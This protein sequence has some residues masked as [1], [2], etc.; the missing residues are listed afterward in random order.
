M[1]GDIL[2]AVRASSQ[3]LKNAIIRSVTLEQATRTVTIEIV[4]D[5]TFTE[6]DKNA[7]T[8]A[9]LPAVPKYFKCNVS[10]IKL[11]PD[12]KM[13]EKKI[14][15][16]ISLNFKAIYVTLKEGD[17]RV[18]KTDYGF[19]YTVAVMRFLQIGQDFCDKINAFLKSNFCG[20]FRGACVPSERGISDISVE[21]KQDEIEFQIPVRTFAI[22]DFGYLEGTKKLTTAVYLA[23]LNFAAEEVVVCGVIE[24]ITER[25]YTNKKGIQKSFLS[26]IISDTT[27]SVHI[28]YFI[29][30]KSYEKIKALKVGDSIVCTGSNE[31]YNGC[32][33]YT[34][35]TIDYGKYPK[36]FVPEKRES[37]PVPKYYHCVEPQPFSDCEQTDLFTKSV[38]PECLINNTFVVFD[39]ETTGLNS[40]P[41]SGN[42]DR[43]IEI[44]AYKI[45]EGQICES[46][47]TFINPQRK[48]SDDIIRLT[49]ITENMIAGA[50]V[51][52]DVMPD[53]YKFCSGSILV[54]HN[55]AGF[56]FKFVEYYCA[57]LGYVL[58]RKIID[59]F[60]LS[61]E[62]LFLSNYKLNTVAEKFN[63]SFNH[64]RATDDALA[65]AKIFIEL[66]KL[67]KSLPKI[68]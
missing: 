61:Q 35:N 52:E 4:T 27:A 41:V 47:A 57:R 24:Q 64:H 14:S 31:I 29:R 56:D 8:Y 10:I 25:V 40:S 5:N 36:G 54:G 12:C 53:F 34:A 59:T 37:K 17:I 32:L 62:L 51:Y 68:V 7:A 3:N 43:I 67:K 45:R 2:G 49:G 42:M 63:I 21:E 58:E 50:P 44:G 13:V 18:E 19:Y 11:S 9:V 38:I 48:L 23:D 66:I 28:T 22:E 39:L 1:S 55:I 20:E 65:T 46:F 15:E 6:T 30:Q 16:A 26:L 33:R 60:P